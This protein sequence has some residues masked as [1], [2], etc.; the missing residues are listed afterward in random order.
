M[1]SDLFING[2]WTLRERLH[3]LLLHGRVTPCITTGQGCANQGAFH[4]LLSSGP[5]VRRRGRHRNNPEDHT[6]GVYKR[7]NKAS[8]AT[9]QGIPS[10]RLSNSHAI[11]VSSSVKL[12]TFF[13]SGYQYFSPILVIYQC[14]RAARAHNKQVPCQS[15]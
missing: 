13:S 9:C 4:A 3:V 15:L 6:V 1:V 7:S 2:C 10:K 5:A 12:S 8:C 11:Y 14:G